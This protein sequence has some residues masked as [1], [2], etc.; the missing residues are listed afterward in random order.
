MTTIDDGEQIRLRLATAADLDRFLAIL[1][2]PG[3]AQWWTGSS[4]DELRDLLQRGADATGTHVFAIEHDGNVVGLLYASEELSPDYRHGSIDVTLA[5]DA[6][7]RGLG[8]DAV[9][10]AV[11]WLI[12][13]RGHHRVTIDPAADN[14]RA[15]ACYRKVGFQPVGIMRHYERRED[16][17]WHDGLLMDLLADDIAL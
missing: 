2:Q 8:T 5:D 1:A 15:I 10:T 14:A 11:Q 4:A 16:G 3:V 6:Q 9:R 12:R 17:M 13:D 7:N